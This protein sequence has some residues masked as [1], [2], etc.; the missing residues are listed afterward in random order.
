MSSKNASSSEG[1]RGVSS[2]SAMRSAAAI[3][4]ISAESRPRTEIAPSSGRFDLGA[5]ADEVHTEIVLTL[6]PDVHV[7]ETV[8]SEDRLDRGI[9]DDA[10]TA[11]HDHVVGRL[12]DLAHQVT[13]DEHGPS[14][15][16]EPAHRRPQ[17][18]D[19]VGIEPVGRL[20]EHQHAEGRR[21]GGSD[22]EPLAHAEREGPDSA[23]GDVAEP[24]QV[25]HSIDPGWGDGVAVG[26]PEQMV[27]SGTSVLDCAA[28]SKAPI[29]R[30]GASSCC[31]AAATRTMPE[32]GAS[33]PRIIRIV[34]DLPAPF[35][36]RKPVTCPG[37]TVKEM[38]ST[39][40][41]SP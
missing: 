19:P 20:V 23:A 18:E 7:G 25:E 41:T 29:A 13:R 40:T 35:G 12:G 2:L 26:E 22:A 16:G 28:S 30:N 32:V 24:D 36:P 21:A 15:S 39:A 31:T 14:F 4:P 33:R 37:R 6:G 8:L 27:G 17:P 5:V 3:A 1:W 10:P 34:V 9:G 38:S 11:D